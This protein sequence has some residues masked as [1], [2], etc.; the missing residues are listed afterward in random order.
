MS[1]TYKNPRLK[2]QKIA[3]IC[4]YLRFYLKKQTQ[5]VVKGTEWQDIRQS[6]VEARHTAI[7]QP[8]CAFGPLCP[9]DFAQDMLW[10]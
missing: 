4:V 9:F 8:L 10:S 6:S 5:F 2:R 1:K 3:F 7:Q